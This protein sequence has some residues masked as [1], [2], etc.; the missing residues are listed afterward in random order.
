M[1]AVNIPVV[2]MAGGLL[3]PDMVAATGVTNRGMIPFRGTTMLETIAQ[4]FRSTPG[5]GGITVVGEVPES[6]LYARVPDQGGFVDNLFTGL[7]ASG[8]TDLVLIAAC[9]APFLS[10][11]SITDFI[12]YA[13]QLNVDIV[14]PVVPVAECTKLY[15]GM[16]RTAVPLKEGN[17]TGG[18]LMLFKPEFLMRQKD[19]I[20]R[21]YGSRKSPLKLAGMLGL[22]VVAR[23]IITIFIV[24]GSLSIVPLEV[25][26]GR[27][28]G[29]KVKAYISHY[30]EIATD[31][32]K[33]SD[34]SALD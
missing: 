12:T 5:I 16:K 21:A 6:D 9:D 25:A 23:A 32:D 28:L 34:L 18:N 20:A 30:P 10:C 13:R 26:A 4:T 3:K 11:E 33:V 8:A 17:V 7:M 22:S 2:I 24:K 19:Q 15:P 1:N 14:Y 27:L 29:G 31:V